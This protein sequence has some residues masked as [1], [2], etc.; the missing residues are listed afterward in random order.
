VEVNFREHFLIPCATAAYSSFY[1]NLPTVFVGPLHRMA[2]LVELVSHEMSR[3]FADTGVTMPPWRGSRAI[4]SKWAPQKATD[5]L[6]SEAVSPRGASL[7]SSSELEMPAAAVVRKSEPGVLKGRAPSAE[8]EVRRGSTG[9]F[10]P[11]QEIAG[12]CERSTMGNVT[13]VGSLGAVPALEGTRRAGARP[14][15]AR[16][17]RCCSGGSSPA[18]SIKVGFDFPGHQMGK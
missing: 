17:L 3:S 12:P 4:M 9:S 6:P 14:A 7:T 15:Q 13:N 11:H 2:P 10:Q 18:L 16:H 5:R 1:E 8:T